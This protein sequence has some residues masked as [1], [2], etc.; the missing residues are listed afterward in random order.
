MLGLTA[1]AW[2]ALTACGGDDGAAPVDAVVAI[3]AAVDAAIDAP[4]VCSQQPC[5]I[6]PQ[7]GCAQLA[8]TPVC[9]LD[10]GNLAT[11][12][13][14]C[15]ADNFHGTESTLCARASTCAAGYTCLGHCERYCATDADCLGPG[16]LCIL[17]VVNNNQPIPGVKVC[18]TDCAPSQV[19]N[20]RCPTGWACHLYREGDGARRWL[21]NCDP[22][23]A[24]GGDLGATCD[25]STS[26][27]PGL[28]CFNDGSGMGRRCTANCLC[29]GGDCAAAVCPAGAGA[30][31]PYSPVAAMVGTAI[32]GRCYL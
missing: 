17:P 28:D 13:T 24:A 20:P 26:C 31:H 30:C 19:D 5:S 10:P 22:S 8:D 3:D 11:G 25:I 9:D 27:K 18:T 12:G 2:I 29:P 1:L 7:C 23:P 32:Y 16:G 14:R 15:R 4:T 6:L 21:T